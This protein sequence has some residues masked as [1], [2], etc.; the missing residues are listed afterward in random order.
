MTTYQTEF[1][2]KLLGGA[3]KLSV[4]LLLRSIRKL[5]KSSSPTTD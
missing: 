3:V 5:R 1:S 4:R 2:L